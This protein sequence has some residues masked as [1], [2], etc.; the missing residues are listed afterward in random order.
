MKKGCVFGTHRVMEPHGVL[1]QAALRIDNSMEIYDNEILIDVSTLNLDSASF[2]QIKEEAKGDPEAIKET[3]LKTI[4]TRGKQH[5]PVTGSGG[6]LIGQIAALGD[7]LDRDIKPGDRI[8]TLVS[9]SLTPLKIEKITAVNLQ[10]AQ[11]DVEGQAILFESG[12]YAKLPNDMPEKV[13]LAAL[14]VAGAPAQVSRLVNT[15][16]TVLVLG[17]GGKSGLL[18]LHEAR[19]Q[20][21]PDGLV[22]AVARSEAAC[23]RAH[24]TRLADVILSA[25]A[26]NAMEVYNLVHEATNGKLAHVAI[27]CTNVPR[28]E[29]STILPT[30]NG[31]KAYFFNMATSFTA[32]ALGAEG[33][34]KDV[35]LIIGN[36]YTQ[37]HAEHTLNILRE[38]ETLGAIFDSLSE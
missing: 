19:K 34:G 12:V 23:K 3:I 26:T 36:G 20:A 30:K 35:E 9:L 4:Q 28:T 37:G 6:M 24:S 31:G 32:A 13:A 17:A 25:D 27:N 38:N 15:G 33:V 21:G 29:M 18:C 2:H 8:A 11:V 1:P 5:N 7:K 14:D 22:I 10:T 16:D